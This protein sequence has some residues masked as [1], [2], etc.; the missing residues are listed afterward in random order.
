[1]K[2]LLL[3]GLIA[4]AITACDVY[5]VEPRYDH[6]DNIVGYYDVNEYSETFRDYTNFSFRVEKASRRNEIL[7]NNFYGVDIRVRAYLDYD[8]ITIPYQVV[9]GYEVEGTGT[10]EYGDIFLQYSVRDLYHNTWTDFC[11]ADAYRD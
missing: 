9:N 1:M 5:V 3:F 4:V 11:Q 7:I 2:R 10:V 8:V 6:R